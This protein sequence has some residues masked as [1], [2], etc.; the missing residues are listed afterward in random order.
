[1]SDGQDLLYPLSEFYLLDGLTL[2]AVTEID[3]P[4]LPEPYKTL[5]VHET[6]MT[7]TLEKYHSQ[8]LLL[9]VL[10]RHLEGDE[11][12]REVLLVSE[13]NQKPVEFGAIKINLQHFSKELRQQILE[14]RRPLGAI[15]YDEKIPYISRP[16][17]F[18]QVTPDAIMKRVLGLGDTALLFGRRNILLG[19]SQQTLAE[20]LEVLPPI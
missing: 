18:I 6:D 5:L 12:S 1:M 7:S 15:L 8:K 9:H 4:Q 14:E 13:R 19:P 11:Y 20:I 16:I 10:K 17:A 2:P 3:G